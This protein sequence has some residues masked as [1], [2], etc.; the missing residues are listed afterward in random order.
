MP[1]TLRIEVISD[2][3]FYN[4]IIGILS[5]CNG[6]ISICDSISNFNDKGHIIIVELDNL[7]NSN[8][9]ISMIKEHESDYKFLN[10]T[11]TVNLANYNG[12]KSN[13]SIISKK[14]K[15]EES[16]MDISK[17]SNMNLKNTTI[18]AQDELYLD[19]AHNNWTKQP[20]ASINKELIPNN[21]EDNTFDNYYSLEYD[22]VLNSMAKMNINVDP[23]LLLGKGKTVKLQ[24]Q[25]SKKQV[26][27]KKYSGYITVKPTK[28]SNIVYGEGYPE[29]Y[30]KCDIIQLYQCFY[31][32]KHIIVKKL[33]MNIYVSLAEFSNEVQASTCIAILQEFKDDWLDLKNLKLYY[34]NKKN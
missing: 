1:I 3:E 17:I 14:R 8:T 15:R 20:L 33:K 24:N 18:N 31:G 34:T 11:C 7:L 32:L 6:I 19:D 16:N 30:I 13:K 10:I 23:V 28:L 25:T 26:K 9:V 4:K 5:Y 2:L 27:K 12:C 22:S 29:G 21:I